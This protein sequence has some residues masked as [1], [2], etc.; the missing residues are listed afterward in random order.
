MLQLK[1]L[2][3]DLRE[4]PCIGWTQENLIENFVQDGL[5]YIRIPNGLCKL[6]LTYPKWPC[7]CLKVGEFSIFYIQGCFCKIFCSRELWVNRTHFWC[8]FASMSNSDTIL[9]GFFFHSFFIFDSLSI[10]FFVLVYFY[11]YFIF[12]CFYFVTRQI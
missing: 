2:S 8:V 9:Y 11:F 6:F 7:V 3:V 10:I 1:S 12:F 5:S 4:E